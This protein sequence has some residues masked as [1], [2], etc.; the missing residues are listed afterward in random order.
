VEGSNLKD[1]FM[2]IAIY[3]YGYYPEQFLITEFAENL[4]QGGHQVQVYTG[5]PNYPKGKFFEGYSLAKGPYREFRRGVE[6]VRYPMLARG[7]GFKCLAMNYLSHLLSGLIFLPRL[8]KAEVHFIFGPSP[9]TISIPAIIKA[10]LTGGKVCLWLQDLW[11]ESIAAVGALPDSSF[12]Y[13][14]I[15]RVVRWIYAKLDLIMIQSPAFQENLDQF[16]YRGP[17]QYVP[18]WAPE[19]PSEDGNP[20]PEWLKDFPREFTITF[21]GNVG[22]AQGIDTILQSALMMRNDEQVKFVIV[23]DGRALE[24]SKKFVEENGLKNVIFYG[25]RPLEDMSALF[26]LSH[27]LLVTLK[28]NPIFEKT[29]PSKVQAYMA[30]GKPILASL[31]GI[32]AKTVWESGSGLA[33][34]AEDV[35][36]LVRNIQSM[37]KKNLEE[38]RKYGDCARSHFHQNFQ[39]DRIIRQIE[40]SL[41]SLK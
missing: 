10:R 32:G 30:A 40:S 12:V 18:N 25:R 16:G 1:N 34:P 24:S 26:F 22:I 2:H 38:L 5:L 20:L 31:D 19:L 8:K 13:K 41:E 4:A 11:P 33:S 28:K 3:T 14:V 35:E 29:I 37:K 7:K 15:G 17:F 39:K 21:A 23:G 6:I 9:I 36:G 27:C